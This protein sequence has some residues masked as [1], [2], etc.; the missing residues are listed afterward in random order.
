MRGMLV[1][2]RRETLDRNHCDRFR[3]KQLFE[4]VSM[5]MDLINSLTSRIGED[6]GVYL[7]SGEQE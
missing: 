2:S 3:E 5:L 1:C 4:I 7:G 6:L